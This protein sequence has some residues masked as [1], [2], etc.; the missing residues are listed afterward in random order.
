MMIRLCKFGGEQ[1]PFEDKVLG[2]IESFLPP[3]LSQQLDI[4]GGEFKKSA[5]LNEEWTKKSRSF[6]HVLTLDALKCEGVKSTMK[7]NLPK[8]LKMHKHLL[9]L[10]LQT[11]KRIPN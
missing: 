6:L 7:I 9:Q 4:L 10:F 11:K 1:Y 8:I 3:I 2:L 5:K